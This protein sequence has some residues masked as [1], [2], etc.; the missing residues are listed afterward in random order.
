MDKP[1]LLNGRKFDIRL[2]VLVT[3][4][5]PLRCY[6][7]DQGLARLASRPYV[8]VGA[9]GAARLLQAPSWRCG[10]ARTPRAPRPPGVGGFALGRPS[11]LL[12]ALRTSAG[13][14]RAAQ[15]PVGGCGA[16]VRPGRRRRCCGVP[17]GRRVRPLCP[18]DQLQHLQE[19]AP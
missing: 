1:L 17:P 9:E 4:F 8:E 12:A 14:D 2:Y 6:V 3:S 11:W 15:G 5:D 10:S 19:G 13:A 7:Y 18:P 16:A